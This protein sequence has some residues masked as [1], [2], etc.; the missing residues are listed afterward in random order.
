MNTNTTL[1][2]GI[3]PSFVQYVESLEDGQVELIEPATR[4]DDG[5]IF[6]LNIEASDF[7][8]ETQTGSLQFSGSVIFTGYFGTM[9]VEV[10]NPLLRIADGRGE[11]FVHT[12]SMFTDERLDSL[13]SVQITS[14]EQGL[15]ATT[16]LTS[17]G[18][19]I[20]GQQYQ[21]GQELSELA[22]RW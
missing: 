11:L 8:S 17:P 15:H 5:F 20:L 16:R 4:N 6:P 3:K 7:D 9:R 21:V 2:W 19:M 12:P 18:R 10:R 1:V 13:V 14:T 22:V